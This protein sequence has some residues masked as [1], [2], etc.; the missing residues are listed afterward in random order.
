MKASIIKFLHTLN[1]ALGRLKTLLNSTDNHINYLPTLFRLLI[2]FAIIFAVAIFD[3]KT[4]SNPAAS[5]EDKANEDLSRYEYPSIKE[6][7]WQGHF[8]RP[9]DSL[10]RLFGKDWLA[11]A[12]FNRIDRRHVYPGMTIK[13][14]ENIDKIKDYTP[15]PAQYEKA[16]T[17]AK[18]I[19][20]NITEQWIGAYEYGRLVFSMPA[21]TGMEG[22][23]TPVGM[24]SINAYHRKH[25]SSLYKTATG[26]QQYPMDYALLFH[27][28]KE[29]ILYWLHARDLPGRPASHGCVGLSDEDMQ[30]RTYGVPEKP[31]IN[32]AKKLYAW[33]IGEE[34][35]ALDNGRTQPLA[36]KVPLEIFGDL[37]KRLPNSRSYEN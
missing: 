10:E 37:P 22:H 15:M 21:A 36:N 17:H 16:K 3:P 8:V 19:L 30:L 24:F 27:I 25:T 9:Q 33:T 7:G 18:Y 20:L 14:P 32:D 35:F 5:P 2:A 26:T 34:L 13:V 11:I 12:R 29:N 4:I 23:L 6:I 1:P 28:D 31:L